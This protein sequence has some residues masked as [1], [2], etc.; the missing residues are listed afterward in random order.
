MTPDDR[1]RRMVLLEATLR[2]ILRIVD[3]A[4]SCSTCVPTSASF[5]GTH[6]VQWRDILRKA[7]RLVRP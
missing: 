4:E 3:A 7:K 5:D 1:A 6:A 2:E